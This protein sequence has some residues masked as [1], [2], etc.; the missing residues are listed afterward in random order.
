MDRVV[1]VLLAISVCAG[2]FAACNKNAGGAKVNSPKKDTVRGA[3]P[4]DA[5]AAEAQPDKR[6]IDYSKATPAEKQKIN[7]TAKDMK[8]LRPLFR[9]ADGLYR[10]FWKV[11]IDPVS[12]KP[13]NIFKLMYWALDANYTDKGI[14]VQPDLKKKVTCV[15]GISE[16]KKT[17]ELQY[18]VY[19]APCSNPADLK[20]IAQI[21]KATDRWSVV[22]EISAMDQAPRQMMGLFMNSLNST[23]ESGCDMIAMPHGRLG[24]LNCKNIGQDMTETK[25][26]WIK[27]LKFKYPNGSTDKNFIQPL[28]LLYSQFEVTGGKPEELKYKAV[29]HYVK[30][31]FVIELTKN[32]PVEQN[33]DAANA[34]IAADVK[35]KAAEEN[36][37][38]KKE[39]DE[40]NAANQQ[41]AQPV[42]AD[43][44]KTAP[45][46]APSAGFQQMEP[47]DPNQEQD[48]QGEEQ[49]APL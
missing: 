28:V 23:E 25:Y 31:E 10:E 30:S 48:G 18:D 35:A 14:P 49:Q 4:T 32:A 9:D 34:K 24:V 26:T 8:A 40:R 13:E 1:K 16:I 36:A 47:A 29:D 21:N 44:N 15:I 22:F 12:P 39:E 20:K 3:K 17:S 37:R 33:D 38:L 19:F 41:Q 43:A 6:G 27:E 42:A 45:K 46:A 2:V 7:D 5:K 11:I